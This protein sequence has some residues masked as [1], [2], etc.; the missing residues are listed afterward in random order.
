MI[1]FLGA[2]F[3]VAGVITAIFGGIEHNI[4]VLITGIVVG[5]IGLILLLIRFGGSLSS[6]ADGIADGIGGML[7]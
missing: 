5:V 7:D 3:L 6:L 2:L 1:G 4:P